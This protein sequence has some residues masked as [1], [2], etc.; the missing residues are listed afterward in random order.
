MVR[1]YCTSL[2]KVYPTRSLTCFLYLRIFFFIFIVYFLFFL[3]FVYVY[4]IVY[5]PKG[6]IFV[7][8]HVF[9]IIYVLY[10]LYL[11]RVRV[12]IL[13]TARSLSVRLCIMILGLTIALVRDEDH[14][15]FTIKMRTPTIS[16]NSEL[17]ACSHI[18]VHAPSQGI[19]SLCYTPISMSL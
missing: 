6:I 17:L 2:L 8:L 7:D 4:H 10:Y 11:V 13:A 3:Y 19:R 12:L 1:V 9:F 14:L 18:N 16:F 15:L 5:V